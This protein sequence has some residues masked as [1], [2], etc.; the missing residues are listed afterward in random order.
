MSHHPRRRIRRLAV[1]AA[2]LGIGPLMMVVATPAAGAPQLQPITAQTPPSTVTPPTTQPLRGGAPASSSGLA[3][4]GGP[5][6]STTLSLGPLQPPADP[7]LFDIPGR[8]RKA[9]DQ[10]FQGMV[11]AAV[12]PAMDLLGRTLL[13]TPSVATGDRA[14]ELWRL[15]LGL[16]DSAYVLLVTIA[17]VVLLAHESLQV[18]YTVKQMERVVKCAR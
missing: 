16:A 13:A 4:G 6:A 14:R 2:L 11:A 9:I 3:P 1:A 7:G 18:Q 15:S 10:W 5:A 8:I 17:G 12:S